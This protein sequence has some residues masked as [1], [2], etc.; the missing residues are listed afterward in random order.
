MM[1]NYI[2]SYTSE[3]A[4]EITSKAGFTLREK[5]IFDLRKEGLTQEQCAEALQISSKTVLRELKK[6]NNKILRIK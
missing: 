1:S 5:Q 6:I 2:A 4:Q 3:E